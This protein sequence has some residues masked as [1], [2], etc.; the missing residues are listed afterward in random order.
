MV[1]DTKN[2]KRLIPSISP[3]IPRSIVIIFSVALFSLAGTV[4]LAL[5]KE[6]PVEIWGIKI[7]S[8]ME[9]SQTNDVPFLLTEV[10]QLK[11][12][13]ILLDKK[14]AKLF[15]ENELNKNQFNECKDKI[16]LNSKG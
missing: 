11:E 13:R 4:G 2:K 3:V 10:K 8:Q 9:G 15:D 5:Y 7:G 12:Q 16:L 14:M 6:V 1:A